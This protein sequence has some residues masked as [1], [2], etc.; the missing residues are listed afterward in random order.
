[1]GSL[2]LERLQLWGGL[3]FCQRVDHLPVQK[4]D[5]SFEVDL[6]ELARDIGRQQVLCGCR[7]P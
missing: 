1:M 3:A 4:L 7:P 6:D 2:P 5:L